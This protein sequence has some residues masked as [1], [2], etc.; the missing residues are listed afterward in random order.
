MQYIGT[1][2]DDLK[3]GHTTYVLQYGEEEI[4][5]FA[6]NGNAAIMADEQGQRSNG[7][8]SGY[9]LR[10]GFSDAVCNANPEIMAPIYV[11]N[12]GKEV[13]LP[14]VDEAI[15]QI[16]SSK[17][18]I[19]GFRFNENVTKAQK[20]QAFGKVV[21][22]FV[23]T[24][25]NADFSSDEN[26]FWVTANCSRVIYNNGG[27]NRMEIRGVDVQERLGLNTPE[28]AEERQF[29]ELMKSQCNG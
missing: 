13:Q 6:Y 8:Q 22:S 3:P 14:S 10:K 25:K 15:D 24:S 12:E 23:S 7:Y 26:L 5:F 1:T 19:A 4:R 11:D 29:R 18:S 20:E 17:L 2:T 27:D 9:F 28:V 16:Y 21:N